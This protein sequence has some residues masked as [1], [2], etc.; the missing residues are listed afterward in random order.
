MKN[1]YT[2]TT[3]L[4]KRWWPIIKEPLIIILSVSL[5]LAIL[6]PTLTIL[7]YFQ[8]NNPT[9]FYSIIALIFILIIIYLIYDDYQDCKK[10]YYQDYQERKQYY[11]YCKKLSQEENDEK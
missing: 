2:F 5:I 9:I 7:G 6:I 10:E 4:K 8:K 11:E 1:K 3:Y